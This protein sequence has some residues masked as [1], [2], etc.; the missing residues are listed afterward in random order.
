MLVI[1]LVIS[2]L[3]IPHVYIPEYIQ[4]A[5]MH[6]Y[7]QTDRHTYMQVLSKAFPLTASCL[8][9]LSV[10]EYHA[11][12]VGNLPVTWGEVVV[13]ARVLRFPPIVTTG[14]SQKKNSYVRA[15]VCTFGGTYI[16]IDT[17][18]QVLCYNL[19]RFFNI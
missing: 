4:N 1:H 10:L 7:R 2:I 6:A 14:Y 19:S 15:Y 16:Y 3:I 12:R 5:C 11:G 8:S 18:S 9:S 13:F 17:D